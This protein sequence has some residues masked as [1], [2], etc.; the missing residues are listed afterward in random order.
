MQCLKLFRSLQ[1]T[2]NI[3]C[4]HPSVHLLYKKYR[5]TENEFSYK[6]V[7]Y[8]VIKEIQATEY[9]SNQLQD[10]NWTEKSMEDV[11][12]GFEETAAYCSRTETCLSDDRFDSLVETLVKNAS[13]LTFDQL[14]VT[15]KALSMFPET[16][17]TFTKNFA[18]LW[19]R[20]DA[21]CCENTKD[22]KIDQLLAICDLWYNLNLSKTGRFTFGALRKISRK[23]KKLSNKEFIQ[24]LFY[25]NLCRRTMENMF[26]LEL[27]FQDCLDELTINEAGIVCV[28][29]FKTESK[30]HLP[31]LVEKLYRKLGDNIETVEDITL[32]NILKVDLSYIQINWVNNNLLNY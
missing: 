17:S 18:P 20:L 3:R 32:V 9:K 21:V 11:V 12:K 2:S 1:K 14:K 6:I 8:G 15:L 31:L 4:F 7:N 19:T 10:E 27:K 30:F 23:F 13:S 24:S 5:N 25:I 22:W 28:G 16:E 29:F 26:D